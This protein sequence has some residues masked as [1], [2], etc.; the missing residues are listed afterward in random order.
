MLSA[1]TRLHSRQPHFA[2]LQFSADIYAL[3]VTA[4]QALTGRLPFRGPDF[5]AQQALD[6]FGS[7]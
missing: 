1:S 4:F 7:R 3:G 5:V 6:F 2:P